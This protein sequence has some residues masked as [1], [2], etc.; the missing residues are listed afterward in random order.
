MI[1]NIRDIGTIPIS[2]FEIEP[3]INR[4]CDK[5]MHLLIKEWLADVADIFLEKKHVWSCYVQKHYKASTV[6]IEKYFR[7]IN[8]L[9]SRQLRMMVMKTLDRIKDYFMEY[10]GGNYFKGNY[11]DLMFLK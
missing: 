3:K 6:L 7:S 2:A 1:I 11:K 10:S 9:L 5:A 8:T 4:L